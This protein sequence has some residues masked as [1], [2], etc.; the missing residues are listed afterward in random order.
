MKFRPLHLARL[1]VC[2]ALLAMPS[3]AAADVTVGLFAPT[4]PFDGSADRVTF[5][6]AVANHLTDT[7]GAGKVTGKVYGSASAFNAAVKKGEIDFALVDAPFAAASGLPYTV[8]ASA[9]RG[10]GATASWQLI[11][12][13]SARSIR[14]LRGA[15]VAIPSVGAKAQAFV[16]N[17][18]LGGE[19]DGSYFSS[20][21][22]AADARSAVTMITLGKVSAAFVPA[23]IEPVSGT[24][25]IASLSDIG[26][27]MFVALPSADG[28]LA[29]A[30]GDRIKSFRGAAGFTGFGDAGAGNYRALM[31]SFGKVTKRGPMVLPPRARLT[32]KDLLAGRTFSVPLSNVLDIVEAPPPPR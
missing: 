27:P 32:V 9:L 12:K 16:A 2:A 14:D 22:E 4:A 5:V 28:K 24:Q 26:W 30:F 18:L 6:N 20:I 3:A 25:R 13:S 29:S 7:A 21:V 23:G 15:K 31:A 8:L 11:A 1:A 19:V 10:N 17:A